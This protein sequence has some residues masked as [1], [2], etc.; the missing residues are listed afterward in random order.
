MST[1]TSGSPDRFCDIVM[2][3]GIASGIV[4]PLA[5]ADLANEYQFRSIGGTSAG[6]VAAVVTAAA[7]YQR[8]ETGKMDGFKLLSDVPKGLR[9]ELGESEG[10]F[11]R[12]R[13]WAKDKNERRLKYLFQPEPGGCERLFHVLIRAL[14]R[15]SAMTIA[16]AVV[17]GFMEAYWPAVA[18]GVLV[19]AAGFFWYLNAG[20]F[21][22]VVAAVLIAVVI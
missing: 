1:N 7:E 16:F 9:E 19:G 15:D 6:A 20:W 3:G 22:A 13:G 21:P 2:K 17:R 5:V 12:F 11:A 4:Y 10:R 18:F 8:R 14:N